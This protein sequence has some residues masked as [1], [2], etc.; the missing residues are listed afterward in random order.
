MNERAPLIRSAFF[1]AV[2][3]T[4]FLALSFSWNYFHEID[5]TVNLANNKLE[6]IYKRTNAFR[7]WIS[8]HGGIYVKID[9][10]IQ[11]NPILENDSNRDLTTLSGINLTLINTPYLLRDLEQNYLSG[12]LDKARMVSSQPVNP[13]N[14]TDPWENKAIQSL[15]NG[16]EKVNELVIDDNGQD[17]MRLI[18]P[19]HLQNEC[20]A[21]H[22][23]ISIKE[24]EIFGGLSTSISMT[25]YYEQQSL[26]IK[27]LMLFH[28]FVWALGLIGVLYFYKNE[29]RVQAALAK[30]KSSDLENQAKSEFLSSMSHELRTPLN[31]ILGF[32]QLLESDPNAPLSKSQQESVQYIHNGGLHLLD[33]VNQ[34]LE[35]SKIEAGKLEVSLEDVHPAE[36]VAECLTLLE[37][38]AEKAN[39]NFQLLGHPELI[40]RADRLLL[41]QV[42][43]NL[44]SNAIKYNKPGGRVTLDCP[45][46]EGNYLRITVSDTGV[47]IPQDKQS[48]LFTAFSRLGQETSNIEGTGIGLTITQRIIKAM[49]GRI[50][51]ESI[52]GEGS[53]FWFE[54]PLV[55]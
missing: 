8:S 39:V 1:Q 22:A 40:V 15:A 35:L 36:V 55:K 12:H 38:Q 9:N 50:G 6:T 16:A 26:A 19:I 11:P 45:P 20:L 46:S 23:G 27:N 29:I 21:C 17:V 51:F 34:V 54:L 7:K 53:T 5:S 10:S 3:W 24:G 28:I 31:A 41:K 30:Q 52:E 13:L 37:S 18:R 47:G 42:I 49:N 2:L 14:K 48:L 25:P 43:L 32:T 4:I 33:L 44:V